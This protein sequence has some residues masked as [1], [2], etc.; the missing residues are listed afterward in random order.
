MPNLA[1]LV[2]EMHRARRQHKLKL[3][4]QPECNILAHTAKGTVKPKVHKLML[5]FL[6]QLGGLVLHICF[7]SD[8]VMQDP[9]TIT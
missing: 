2:K 1:F 6:K 7:L 4:A 5:I 3:Q 8:G 9:F